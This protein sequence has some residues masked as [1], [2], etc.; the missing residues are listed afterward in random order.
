MKKLMVMGAGTYQVPLI[1][2]AKALGIYTIAVFLLISADIVPVSNSSIFEVFDLYL[3][4]HSLPY[5]F[6]LLLS[7]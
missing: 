3:G 2:R 7:F 4:S 1:K 5:R 6:T